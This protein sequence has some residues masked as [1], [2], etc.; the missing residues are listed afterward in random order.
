MHARNLGKTAYLGFSILL[1]AALTAGCEDPPC[2]NGTTLVSGRCIEQTESGIAEA[3]DASTPGESMNTTVG[4]GGGTAPG[5]STPIAG[6]AG[7]GAGTAGTPAS[8]AGAGAAAMSGSMNASGTGVPTAGTNAQPPASESC[9]TEGTIRCGLS[10]PGLRERCSGGKWVPV[11][12]CASGETC[13]S[14][15]SCQPVSAL[16]RGSAGEAICDA[17][18]AMLLCNA[19]GTAMPLQTCMSA[20]LC[21]AGLP[22]RS[23]AMCIPNEHACS[24]VTLQVCAPDGMGLMRVEDCDTAGLCNAMLGRCTA[25]VC[26]PNKKSCMGNT[27]VT[28]NADGTALTNE[29]MQC[30]SGMCDNAG[31][32]CNM[33]VPGEKS[34]SGTSAQTCDASGQSY[35]RSPCASGHCLGAGK[36]VEC[37]RD[38]DCSTTMQCKTAYCTT[39]NRCAVRDAATR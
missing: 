23:C 9:T 38:A 35:Q 19:D 6:A 21:R 32:D 2:P 22:A 18:G 17:Q 3:M 1:V 31:G 4:S 20:A 25:A 30:A 39:D 10:D 8:I 36:C 14:D 12:A 28:C 29:R 13:T 7:P 24:G 15:G 34:C 33:C 27:L 5:V 16:C 26:D 37:E 11:S